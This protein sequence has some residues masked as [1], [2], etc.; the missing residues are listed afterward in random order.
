[1]MRMRFIGSILWTVG[2]P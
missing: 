1:M 2:L